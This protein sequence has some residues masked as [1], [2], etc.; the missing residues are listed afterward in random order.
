MKLQDIRELGSNLDAADLDGNFNFG[1]Y[2]LEGWEQSAEDG[3][4]QWLDEREAE[5]IALESEQGYW[6]DIVYGRLDRQG[7]QNW[8]QYTYNR[9]EIA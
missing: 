7:R 6:E 5:L 9:K 1:N 4:N 3:Y 2:Y 8:V